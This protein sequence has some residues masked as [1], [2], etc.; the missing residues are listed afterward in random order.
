MRKPALLFFSFLL[1]ICLSGCRRSQFK[2]VEFEA[3]KAPTLVATVVNTPT[4]SPITPMPTSPVDDNCVPNLTYL[5][6]VTV[7]D[8]TIF[9]PGD[10][11]E[12]TWAVQNTGSCVWNDQ[13][14]LRHIDGSQM[15]ADSRQQLPELAPGEEGEITV[16]FNAPEYQG[17]YWSSWQAYDAKGN[18]FGDDIYME[19]YVDP[20]HTIDESQTDTQGDS[21]YEEYQY[22]YY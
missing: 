11:I 8:G 4:V 3:Y 17:G 18:A 16:I 19:I 6:D 5:D 20:Y 13:F 15:D 9:V 14:S 10:Y 12:K 1:C 2:G 21:D 22:Y 7:P